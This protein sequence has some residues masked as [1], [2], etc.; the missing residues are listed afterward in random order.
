MSVTWYRNFQT[1][2]TLIHRITYKYLT[3]RKEP[4]LLKHIFSN[5]SP[6]GYFQFIVIV[7]HA[8]KHIFAH[9]PGCLCKRSSRSG[10]SRS[11]DEFLSKAHDPYCH[12]A[13]QEGCTLHKIPPLEFPSWLEQLTKPTRIHEDAGSIPGLTQWI[14]DLALS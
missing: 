11:K 6:I 9:L 1:L 3:C 2:K 4:L 8:T 10:I 5:H 12:V 7:I 14:K 13:L